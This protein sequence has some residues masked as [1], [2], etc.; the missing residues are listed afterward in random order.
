MTGHRRDREI[1]KS[2]ILYSL[3]LLYLGLSVGSESDSESSHGSA[4]GII[5]GAVAGSVVFVLLVVLLLIGLY[6]VKRRYT[7]KTY[8]PIHLY[9]NDG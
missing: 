4:G 2:L 3:S 8:Y 7:N 6:F 1:G 5:G 9:V